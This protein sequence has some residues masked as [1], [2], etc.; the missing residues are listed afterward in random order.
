M[1]TINMSSW[2]KILYYRSYNNTDSATLELFKNMKYAHF[3]NTPVYYNG[4]YEVYDYSMYFADVFTVH[5]LAKVSDCNNILDFYIKLFNTPFFN[6]A[7]AEDQL[8]K[9]L[10]LL[11]IRKLILM[12]SNGV[13]DI[14]SH[15]IKNYIIYTIKNQIS[16]GILN[17][18]NPLSIYDC[19]GFKVSLNST[20]IRNLTDVIITIN[21][22]YQ[23]INSSYKSLYEQL[24]NKWMMFTQ[25]QDVINDIGRNSEL[26]IEYL[27][28]NHIRFTQK[29]ILL[30]YSVETE[31]IIKE[32]L[33]SFYRTRTLIDN[34]LNFLRLYH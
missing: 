18:Q 12:Q 34:Y 28:Y 29:N 22:S 30:L 21:D 25:T 11:D 31:P 16:L 3:C 26:I 10:I 9:E 32:Y 27:R 19:F 14:N 24:N 7:E 8:N 17:Y 23:Q 33:D 5:K 6:N 13:L 20:T 4:F 15:N 2:N 1:D